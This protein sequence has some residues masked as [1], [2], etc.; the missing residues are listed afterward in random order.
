M[1]RH[2]TV[3][4]MDERKFVTYLAM[5]SHSGTKFPFLLLL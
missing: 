5:V 4:S 2:R 1:D 3:D